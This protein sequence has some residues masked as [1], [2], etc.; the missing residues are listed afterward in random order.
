MNEELKWARIVRKSTGSYM[1]L[2]LTV[3]M[4]EWLIDRFVY[5]HFPGWEV[6][7]T[8]HVNPDDPFGEGINI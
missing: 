5:V 8:C 1:T 3:A 7:E 4:S 6:V 2:E